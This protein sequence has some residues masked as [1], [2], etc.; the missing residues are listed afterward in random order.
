MPALSPPRRASAARVA[1]LTRSRTPDDPDLNAAR[2]DLRAEALAEAIQHTVNAA[3]PLTPAQV[4]R[5]AGLLRGSASPGSA[6]QAQHHPV[7]VEA[8]AQRNR[9]G[10]A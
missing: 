1:A 7:V 10:A 9:A 6:A 2:L 5:L 8:P 4:D 3:P